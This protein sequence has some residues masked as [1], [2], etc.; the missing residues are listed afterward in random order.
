MKTLLIAAASAAALTATAA[1]AQQIDPQWYVRGDVGGTFASRIDGRNGA[2]SDSGWGID[3]GVGRS[4]GNGFRV[5]GE[6]LYLDGS[7]KNHSA[8]VQ[9]TGAFLN[10]YYDF[11]RGSAWQPYVGAG[12][13]V[14]Q[15][16]T[17]GGTA[18]VHGEDTRFAYQLK[19]GVSHPFNDRLTGD[20][21][22]R[23]LRVE[24]VK[25]GTGPAAIN[26]AYGTSA[27]MVGLRYKFGAF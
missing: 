16:R 5:E 8:D 1:S 13:G 25:I 18:L 2:R 7:G 20:L 24:D 14:A 26:G 4:L 19:A 10:G 21:G 17:S 27:V 12:V 11:R 23:Y 9:T 3:A 22:Y 15:V 6:A